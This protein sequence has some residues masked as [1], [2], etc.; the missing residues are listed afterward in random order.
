MKKNY[1]IAVIIPTYSDYIAETI[2]A[3]ASALKSKFS[4]KEVIAVDD[5]SEK[6][7]QLR[8][9]KILKKSFPNVVL[10]LSAKNQG[11]A[12]TCNIGA[13]IA[14]RNNADILFFLNND[15]VIKEDCIGL[16]VK[17]FID[18]KV[19]IVGPKIYL[20]NTDILNSVGGY[21]DK[22][23]L[24]K[25]EYGSGEKDNG[26]F[27]KKREVEFVMGSA[28]MVSVPVFRELGGFDE[29]FYMYTEETDFCYRTIKAGH[30][31]IYQP[32]AIVWHGHA[33]TFGKT[34]NKVMY[35]H[36][37]NGIYLS[38]KNGN[39]WNV[40]RTIIYFHMTH[41]KAIFKFFVKSLIVFFMAISDGLRG[42]MGKR[43]NKFLNL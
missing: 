3:V 31:V 42:K 10:E 37:R 24:L 7:I 15:A 12:A 14:I 40:I 43:E 8:L 38:K 2:K 21:F 1:K 6:G 13:E 34:K 33:K 18:E 30:K 32:E 5:G 22:R 41:L 27:D 11:F 25:K 29:C 28:F 9:S 36:I 23:T 19:A 4:N 17:E 39:V 35:Y 26:Q 20:G 16:M